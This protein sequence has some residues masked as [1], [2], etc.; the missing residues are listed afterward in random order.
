MIELEY[1]NCGFCGSESYETL[2]PAPENSPYSQCCIVQCSN[3][4][5]VRTN[6][7]PTKTALT[8]LY[9]NQYYSRQPPNLEGLRKIKIFAMKYNFFALF[10]LFGTIIPFRIPKDAAICDVGCGAGQWLAL[11]R[12]AYPDSKLYRFE[13]DRETASIA[14]E[15]CRGDIHF[16]NFLNNSWSSNSFDFI[17]FWDVLEH[18]ENPKAI[19]Q[20][21]ARLLKPNGRVVVVSPNID[22]LYSKIFKQFW[23]ALLFDQHL[24][25][26]S[27]KTLSQLFQSCELQLV[28]STIPLMPSHGSWNIYHLLQYMEFKELKN[29]KKFILLSNLVKVAAILDKLQISRLFSQ[30][31]IMC[32][33]KSSLIGDR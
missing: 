24:Y 25:H 29:T 23:Y 16:G 28:Y 22:C 10:S 31:L 7:R 3:C 5:L 14:A 32:A 4:S 13:I 1:A 2:Y 30:H 17:T 12:T 6:P 15:F 18:V 11:M 8:E 20:E 21:V 26:F 9:T 27:R 33:K 19:M